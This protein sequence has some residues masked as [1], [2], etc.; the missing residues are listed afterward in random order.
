MAV[1]AVGAGSQ[2]LLPCGRPLLVPPLTWQLT[3]FPHMPWQVTLKLPT[4]LSTRPYG[5][6]EMRAL[7]AVLQQL[8]AAEGP[9]IQELYLQ[10]STSRPNYSLWAI[11]DRWVRRDSIFDHL[12]VFLLAWARMPC[13]HDFCF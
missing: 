2:A 7:T 8:G 9:R 1:A 11:L 5:S 3:L 6:A 12:P 13:T 4:H 10:Q